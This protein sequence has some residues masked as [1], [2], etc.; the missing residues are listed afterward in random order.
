[1]DKVT[2][3]EMCEKTRLHLLN[4][5]DRYAGRPYVEMPDLIRS[6]AIV[7]WA[8]EAP[9]ERL[10]KID[11]SQNSTGYYLLIAYPEERLQ[12]IYGFDKLA[13]FMG[14]EAYRKFRTHD[15]SQKSM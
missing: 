8:R 13:F 7:Y 10:P 15:P 2:F 4:N 1:M 14:R 6:E 11:V 12:I 5:S 3:A 9:K